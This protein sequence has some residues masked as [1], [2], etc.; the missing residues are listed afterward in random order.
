MPPPYSK[1]ST[2]V[3]ASANDFNS[4]HSKNQRPN[5][6]AM[7]TEEGK[8]FLSPKNGSQHSQHSRR[9]KRTYSR[10]NN[11][12]YHELDSVSS[13]HTNRSLIT[14]LLPS[15][16]YP[17]GKQEGILENEPSLSPSGH[18]R[19]SRSSKEPWMRPAR[20]RA[21][22]NDKVSWDGLQQTFRAYKLSL[23]HI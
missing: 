8:P 12:Y 15:R 13:R 11:S 1:V 17:T 14:P 5:A 19:R 22:I 10:S 20:S 7:I 21:K 6:P 18:S 23:I 16:W 2:T 3:A 4:Q 9:S